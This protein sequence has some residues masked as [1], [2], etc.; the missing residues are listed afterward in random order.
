MSVADDAI[1]FAKERIISARDT[2]IEIWPGLSPVRF[3]SK[4]DSKRMVQELMTNLARNNPE[5]LADYAHY[6]SQGW[7]FADAAMRNLITEIVLAGK[8]LP[9]PLSEYQNLLE[10]APPRKL[11]GKSKADYILR[12]I[13][14]AIT[15]HEVHERFGL[16]PTNSTLNDNNS[17]CR[18]VSKALIANRM[19]MDYKA[20]ETV[21]NRIGPILFGS[22]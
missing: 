3:L 19:N 13:V 15:V 2:P 10:V 7:K 11:P 14:I 9:G 1:A 17:A 21:W 6:A 12:D 8:P 22:S 18:V 5:L 20:V 4:D 16:A